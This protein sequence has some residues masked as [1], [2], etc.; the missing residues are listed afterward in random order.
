VIIERVQVENFG[1]YYG[2][3][4][5]KLGSGDQPLIV[6]HGENMSGK[7]SFLNAVRWCLY[8]YAKD[9]SGSAF[10]SVSL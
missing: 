1:P 6:I 7:T 5:V 10:A 4:S 2:K 9:R 3:Q 8:G